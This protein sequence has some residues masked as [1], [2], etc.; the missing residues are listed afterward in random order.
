MAF[1]KK[2]MRNNSNNLLKK[3]LTMTGKPNHTQNQIEKMVKEKEQ[4]LKIYL[5]GIFQKD[6][7][8][9]LSLSLSLSLSIYIYIY[10]IY[11]VLALW[12]V[13]EY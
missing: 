1:E 11:S 2:T 9:T 6:N 8:L 4:S 12:L 10:I 5:E 3:I 13:L 7:C